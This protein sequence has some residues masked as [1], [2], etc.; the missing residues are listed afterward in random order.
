MR[1]QTCKLN[2]S[3]K[4]CLLV[5]G[6]YLTTACWSLPGTLTPTLTTPPT[7]DTRTASPSPLPTPT[8]TITLTPTLAPDDDHDN[9]GLSNYQER[10]KY[11]TDP[12][13]PDTDADGVQ[14]GD[15]QERREYVYSVYV[16]MMIRQPFDINVMNDIFQ[17]V[18]IVEG[19]YEDGYTTIEALIYPETQP[20]LKPSPFPLQSLPTQV[21]PYL[22]PGI[23]TNYNDSMSAQ[24]MDI[25]SGAQTDLEATEKVL[26]WVTQNTQRFPLDFS[27][28]AIYF[29]HI[30]NT[31]PVVREDIYYQYPHYYRKVI[32][33]DILEKLYFADSMFEQSID[34]TCNSKATLKCAMLKSVGIPCRTIQTLF[35]LFSHGD[36]Q[37]QYENNLDRK[38]RD[39]FES[40]P[41]GMPDKWAN[42]AFIEAYLGGQWVRA[43]RNVN[44]YHD[45]EDWL[46]L[47]IVAVNDWSEVDFTD[48]WPG[49]WIYDRPYYTLLLEDQ[50][51][52]H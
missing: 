14:D 21:Q 43:D 41:A 28:P 12:Y 49:D 25:I 47:K 48:T 29:V 30:E 8:P 18:R 2:S 34:G 44:I 3:S 46:S 38:W 19:L 52:V 51:P 13:K 6:I 31:E 9:D 37:Y 10:V 27:L 35:L 17:D 15:W 42:H 33:K 32:P 16:R 36:Q 20:E 11:H 39:E 40:Q 7:T 24:V 22:Q 26:N 1:K 5:L 4:L 45:G 23:A 50:E